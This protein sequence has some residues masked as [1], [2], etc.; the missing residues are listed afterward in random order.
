VTALHVEV[1]DEG[2]KQHV[3]R[4]RLD[5][6]ARQPPRSSTANRLIGYT[7]GMTT[8]PP[9]IAGFIVDDEPP[10]PSEPTLQRSFVPKPPPNNTTVILRGV[11]VPLNSD[12]GGAF[13]A[14]CARNRERIFSDDQLREK[15]EISSDA[16]WDKIITN[17]PLRLAI[18]AE[19]ERHMLNGDAA[20]E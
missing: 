5:S 16:D 7:G 6:P 15:Y 4:M 3:R 8:N 9:R 14:D 18:N 20:R 13:T 10:P 19:C 11:S 1:R 17:K 12:V 2:H